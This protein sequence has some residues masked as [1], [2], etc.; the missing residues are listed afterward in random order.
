MLLPS[1]LSLSQATL[2]VG[3]KFLDATLRPAAPFLGGG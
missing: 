2:A 1:A 3:L